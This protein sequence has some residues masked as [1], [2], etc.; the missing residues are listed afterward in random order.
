MKI[1]HLGYSDT[2]GGASIAMMR[3]HNSLL[4][5]NIDSQVLVTEKLTKNKNVNCSNNN[6]IENLISE[7]KIKLARQKKYFFNSGNRYSHSLNFFN[8]NI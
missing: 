8:S 6:E 1:L 5:L 3:L 7:F 4:D 2:N